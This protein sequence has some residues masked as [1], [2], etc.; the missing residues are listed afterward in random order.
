MTKVRLIASEDK[1]WAELVNFNDNFIHIS[2]NFI[3]QWIRWLNSFLHR[4]QNH[5]GIHTGQ[6][7]AGQHA[8]P[9]G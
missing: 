9:T 3:R 1:Y 4:G 7:Y 2:N 8:R 5:R 6:D